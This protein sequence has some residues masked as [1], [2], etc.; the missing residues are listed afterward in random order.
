[1]NHILTCTDGSLYAPSIYE[2]TAW[3]A[4]RQGAAVHVLHMLDP[5]RERAELSDFSGNLGLNTGDELLT[6]L[7]NFEETKN[8]LARERGKAILEDARRRLEAAGVQRVTTEQLHGEL[9]ETVTAKEEDADLVVMGKR[10]ETADLAKLHLG[11][12]LERVI[13]ASIRPVLVASRKF[14]PIERFLIA[15][16]GGPSVEDAVQFVMASPFLKGLPCHLL[17][18]GRID[19][20]AEW[21]LQEAAAKLRDAEFD[22]TATATAGDPAEVIS[23][24]VKKDG[25]SLLVMGAYGHSRIRQLMVGSTTTEMMR[26]CHVPILMFR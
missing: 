26:T 14:V 10:G 20:K 9:V 3:A 17:R 23:E 16:D 4:S 13:R 15:Y 18:A 2:H 7:V 1:M 8:R 19:S 21:Y 24:A 6:E 12:N 25:I 5:H 22:V 11:S